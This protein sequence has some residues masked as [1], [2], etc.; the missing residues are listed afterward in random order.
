MSVPTPVP[1]QYYRP[2]PRSIFGPLALITLGI[3]F[4][5]RTTN[6]VPANTLRIWFAHYWPVLLI[7]WGAAKLIEHLWARQ[8][9]EPT[10]RLG[11]GSIVFLVFFILISTAISSTANW[12][13]ASIHAG[14]WDPDLELGFFGDRY[15]FTDTFAQPLA[16]GTE[17][18][19]LANR[20]DISVSASEDGQAHA[21][22]HKVMRAD[23]QDSANRLHEATNARFTQQGGI[24]LL[25]LTGGNYDHGNFN[26][27]LQLPRKIAL[28][29]STRRGNL[30]VV[31][32]EGS[33]DLTAEHG[34]ATVE[35]VKGDASLHVHGGSVTAR[36]VTGNLQVEGPVDE[37]AISDITG[38]VDL[39][40]RYVTGNLQVSHVGQRLRFKTPVT[41]LQLPKLDG[42]INFGHGDLRGSSVSGPVKLSTRSNEV[43]L[44]DVT[45]EV[46]VENRNG[47]VELRAKA[48]LG[49]IVISNVHGG[50]ELDLPQNAG[51]RLDAQSTD[52]NIDV[53]DFNVN[54]DNSHSNATAHGSV[55]QGGPEIRLRADRGSIQIRKE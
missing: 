20:G 6:L 44:E 39:Q 4:L 32:R 14:D 27:D 41:D 34:S 17:I 12:N 9:G 8:R 42:E 15:Q 54:V 51:F 37:G 19:I 53:G 29:L 10:P 1:P 52:G 3:L 22:V 50:I 28:S 35:Q 26:L 49:N 36:N 38:S 47:V 23:S 45:G 48:P 21:V 11:G 43:H 2:R 40:V 5:L 33:V 31:Q 7:L 55:G 30:N 25:D 46:E 24:W 16:G 13:W 18:K